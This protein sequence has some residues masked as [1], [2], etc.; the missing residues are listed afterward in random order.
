MVAEGDCDRRTAGLRCWYP[1]LGWWMTWHCHIQVGVEKTACIYTAV[2]Q[3][4]DLG[5]DESDAE[6]QGRSYPVVV[7]GRTDAG[8]IRFERGSEKQ[9]VQRL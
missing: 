8:S 1:I 3:K 9:D 4:H 7:E 5:S 6:V 2:G